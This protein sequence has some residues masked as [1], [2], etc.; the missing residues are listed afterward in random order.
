MNI[1]DAY[2]LRNTVRLLDKDSA[3]IQHTP[4]MQYLVEAQKPRSF[5]E[6]GTHMGVS[7]CAACQTIADLKLNTTARAVDTWQGDEHASFYSSEIYATLQRYHDPLYA[8]FSQL[9]RTTFDDALQ[10][11]ADGSLDLIHIDGLHTYEAVKHDYD[12]WLPK[13]AP[14]GI[15]LFHDTNVHERNFGVFQLWRELS[16]QHPG[17]EFL[18]GFGLGVLA[19][20]GVPEGLR[21][22]FESVARPED[23]NRIRQHFHM[24]GEQVSNRAALAYWSGAL[25]QSKLREAELRTQLAHAA[26]ASAQAQAQ[27][28]AQA[29]RLQKKQSSHRHLQQ[30]AEEHAARQLRELARHAHGLVMKARKSLPGRLL[31]KSSEAAA[32][33]QQM[34]QGKAALKNGQCAE[35]GDLSLRVI[36]Q[37][38]EMLRHFRQNFMLQTVVSGRELDSLSAQFETLGKWWATV[39]KFE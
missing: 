8:S 5:V 30:Q 22:L 33:E 10:H 29:N 16:S 2:Y 14:Q 39:R 4:F 19:P 18:H 36:S 7:Y 23:V 35:A 12:T 37:A 25:D 17:F 9:L 28:Q 38:L 26:E 32:L 24:L 15:V 1:P 34:E 11:F 6:L 13:L 20:K 21:S 3:W 31:A 27:I